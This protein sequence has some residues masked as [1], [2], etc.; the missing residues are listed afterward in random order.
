MSLLKKTAGFS[1]LGQKIAILPIV[2]LVGLLLNI[3]VSWFVSLNVDEA[4]TL[5][6]EAFIIAQ[7]S[8]NLLRLETEFLKTLEPE[9]LETIQKQMKEIESSV[10]A[11]KTNSS[12]DQLAD[13]FNQ[14]DGLIQEH[15]QIFDQS[16]RAAT[17]MQNF[18]ST[19]TSHY[20]QGETSLR[21]IIELIT[22]EETNLIMIG[23]ELGGNMIALRD[24]VKEYLT[25][26]SSIVL[27][28]TDLLAFEDI[29]TYQESNEALQQKLALTANNLEGIVSSVENEEVLKNWERAK[30]EQESFNTVQIQLFDAWQ[31]RKNLDRKLGANT[32][33][34]QAAITEVTFQ[35]EKA[36]FGIQGIG[37]IISIV[38]AIATLAALIVFSYFLIRRIVTPIENMTKAVES[39]AM[40]DITVNI[41][42]E[43]KDEL[44]RMASALMAMEE[45]QIEKV[46]LAESIASGELTTDVVLSSEKDALGKALKKMVSNLNITLNE[47]QMTAS[48]VSSGS[49]QVSDS[50]LSLS[51]G[52]T[53]QASTIEEISSTMTQIGSQ[54]STNAENA[55]QADKLALDSKRSAENGTLVMKD[56][57]EAMKHIDN[58]SR[59]IG[60]IIKTVDEI[61]FQTNLLALN[62]AVEAAR[63][64]KYGKGFAVVAEEVRKL[65]SRSADAARETAE[66]ID[67]SIKKVEIGNSFLE[68]TNQALDEFVTSAD[69]VSHLVAEIATASK[70]QDQGI[71]QVNE[72]LAQIEQVTQRNTAN[73]EETASAA[74]DL[75]GMASHLHQLISQFKIR[76]DNEN[77]TEIASTANAI[78]M[79][80]KQ[81]IER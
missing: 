76:Q 31:N 30:A 78:E 10:T 39:M 43:A 15:I 37:N 56:L 23:E 74:E 26:L 18:R 80:P 54:V 48:R 11:L 34:I 17:D 50:S 79:L 29:N 73:A 6:R 45:A 69:K 40:G 77:A 68:K 67:G 28:L 25:H 57:T 51:Q 61:A 8:S 19:L 22:A 66:M 24:T 13:L 65:A 32:K 62:A 59:E 9:T 42:Y 38:T 35:S 55:D 46:K 71:S 5:E 4:V 49:N 14:L 44:G 63:A 27:N 47:V 20:E 70:E 41:E 60:K 58:S 75:S 2:A 16:R 21:N 81:L 64:G 72:G 1:G 7:N 12:D 33:S 36:L 3:G 52:A 53:E